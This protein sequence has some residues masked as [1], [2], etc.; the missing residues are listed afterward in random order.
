MYVSFR[1]G[2]VMEMSCS[3]GAMEVGR[4]IEL[5]GYSKV[6]AQCSMY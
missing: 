4:G 6:Y 3:E 1:R 5:S 2:E